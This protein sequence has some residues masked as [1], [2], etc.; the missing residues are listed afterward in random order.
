MFKLGSE[1]RQRKSAILQIVRNR[2]SVPSGRAAE[3]EV[4]SRPTSRTDDSIKQQLVMTLCRLLFHWVSM[5]FGLNDNQVSHY[6]V[7]GAWQFR[8]V[9]AEQRIIGIRHQPITAL[10]YCIDFRISCSISNWR[11][12]YTVT[13]ITAV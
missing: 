2:K 13:D 5:S 8:P 7:G 1:D 12:C 10:H 9:T 11:R 6:R 3:W 4:R